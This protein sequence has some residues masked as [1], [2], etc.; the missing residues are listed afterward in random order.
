MI[1]ARAPLRITLAGGGT[2]LPSWYKVHGSEFISVAIDKFV[3][4]LVNKRYGLNHLIKYSELEKPSHITDIKHPIIRE[5]MRYFD[6]DSFIEITTTADLPGRTGLGSSSSFTVALLHALAQ[7]NNLHF[8]AGDIARMAC[9]IEI[10]RLGEPIGIQDQYIASFGGLSKFTVT[11]SG[12]VTHKEM[13]V[14]IN[15]YRALESNLLLF[16]TGISRDASKLLE[17]QNRRTM[18]EDVEIIKSLEFTAV[19]GRKI[20]EALIKDRPDEFGELMHEY[21]MRKRSRSSGMSNSFV[22]GVYEI[23][24]KNGAIGGKLVGAG[25]GGFLLL[26]S[27]ESH[28]TIAAL[29]KCNLEHVNFSFCNEGAGLS[30]IF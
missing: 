29:E 26:Y 4:V 1:L 30:P 23:A 12:H 6:I 8:S 7:F 27:V 17:D 15:T 19:L 28:K 11:Q 20:E 13:N 16:Y 9:E 21:W 24:R 18:L 22:D 10:G 2:D 3:Y 14:S 5:S 25:G